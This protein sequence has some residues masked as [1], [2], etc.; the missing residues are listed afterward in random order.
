[1]EN[2][3]HLFTFYATGNVNFF[4]PSDG[5]QWVVPAPIMLD[6]ANELGVSYSKTAMSIAKGDAWNNM[7]QQ[8]WALPALAIADLRAKDIMGTAYPF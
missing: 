8:F 7:F 6:A 4:V 1:L 2:T 5:G 3:F